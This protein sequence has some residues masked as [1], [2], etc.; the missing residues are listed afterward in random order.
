MPGILDKLLEITA[1][2]VAAAIMT[3][4]IQYTGERI[5]LDWRGEIVHH[6][7]KK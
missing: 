4:T 2:G 1:F 3:S 7:H 6:M 5:R